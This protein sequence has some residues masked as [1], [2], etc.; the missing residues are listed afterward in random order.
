MSL[1]ASLGADGARPIVRRGRAILGIGRGFHGTAGPAAL[2]AWCGR[3]GFGRGG[4]RTAS[5]SR[6]L[7]RFGVVDMRFRGSWRRADRRGDEGRKGL[8]VAC[9]LLAGGLAGRPLEALAAV[10]FLAFAALRPLI[11]LALRAALEARL[12]TRAFALSAARLR[13]CRIRRGC[14]LVA[15]IG[16]A[17]MAILPMIVATIVMAVA[18]PPARPSFTALEALVAIIEAL[19]RRGEHRRLIVTVDRAIA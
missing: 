18:V 10:I 9:G 4:S 16:L 3:A 13:R 15:S 8:L 2:G 7:H 1:R 12:I 11:R 17:A 14:A 6:R 5:L 19:T